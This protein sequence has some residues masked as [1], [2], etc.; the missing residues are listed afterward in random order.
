MAEV[1][2]E[3]IEKRR[4]KLIEDCLRIQTLNDG[5]EIAKEGERLQKQAAELEVMAKVYEQQELAKIPKPPV[6]PKTIK[7]ELT[8]EQRKNV[9]DKTGLRIEVVEL[10]EG[11][12]IGKEKYMPDQHP[13]I[14]EYK[15]IKKA[16]RL[17]AKALAEEQSKKNIAAAMEEIAKV[18]NPDLQK[19]LAEK[20][21]DPND[22][23]G[24]TGK[25]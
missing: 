22:L 6:P 7:V 2:L 24:M 18:Q 23:G 8:D 13:G 14:V 21:A 20:L 11:V 19:L 25:S 15:A 10:Q 4:K 1:T 17:K 16:E 3:H 5:E 12:D 9:L